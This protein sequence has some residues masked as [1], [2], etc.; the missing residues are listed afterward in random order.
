[1]KN[2]KIVKGRFG[3]GLSALLLLVSCSADQDG[4]ASSS[5]GSGGNPS[6]GGSPPKAGA[7]AAGGSVASGGTPAGVGGTGTSSGGSAGKAQTGGVSGGG[8]AVASG[9]SAG[10][11]GKSSTGGSGGS[12]GGSGGSAGGGAGGAGGGGGSGGSPNTGGGGGSAGGGGAAGCQHTVMKGEN[13]LTIG[14]SWIQIPGNQVTELENYLKGAG[15]IGQSERFD[16]REVSGAPIDSIVGQ[17]NGK[18]TANVRVL[19]M[20]GGGIDL[21]STPAGNTA[22]VT[23][24]VNKFKSFLQKIKDEGNVQHVIYSLYPVIPTTPNLNSNMKAPFTE[25]CESGPIDCHLV[26]L[27]PLFKGQHIG[28]DR[29]HADNEGGKIIAK[30]WWE[31]MQANCIAQ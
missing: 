14:D 8:G 30:A 5:G 24:V 4:T 6:S 23:T 3:I 17:F 28:S 9:G 26:D 15:V 1:M 7:P 22:A 13:F 20:D 2:S 27:E 19:I 31:T 29:T 18:S 12:T 10:G 21:F 11:A 25:A 16:R